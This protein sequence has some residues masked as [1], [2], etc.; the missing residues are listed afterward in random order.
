M[1]A[2]VLL[3]KVFNFPFT[4]YSKKECKI[5]DLVEVPFGSKKEIGV[6][7]KNY[8]SEPKNL[9]IKD[10]KKITGYSINNRLIDFIEWFSF[11]N[12]VP[13]GLVLKMVIGSDLVGKER[14]ELGV[15]EPEI[16]IY[17]FQSNPTSSF[18]GMRRIYT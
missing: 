9:K 4:Y 11:Y 17:L 18:K 5:G 14:Q 10:I 2:Q 16:Y 3:P 13:M 8:H 6:I 1:K 15:V 12:L 7:W